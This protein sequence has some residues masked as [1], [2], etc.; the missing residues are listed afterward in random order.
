M[1]ASSSQIPTPS[2]DT[3]DTVAILALAWSPDSSSIVTGCHEGAQIW[4]VSGAPRLAYEGQRAITAVAWS[5]DGTRIAS[6]GEDGTIQVWTPAPGGKVL[7]A[8]D[9]EQLMLSFAWSPDGKHIAC[10]SDEK[11]IIW[12]ADRLD[13]IFTYTGHENTVRAVA[14]S[15]DGTRIASASNDNT[16]QVWQ[17]G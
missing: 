8:G 11:V 6:T 17:A 2:L 1:G 16:A 3:E 13:P 15:P 7:S 9:E 10:A 4:D 5:P 12:D 14:W